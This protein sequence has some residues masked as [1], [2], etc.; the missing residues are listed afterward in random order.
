MTS[1][2]MFHPDA[3]HAVHEV[4]YATLRVR[5]PGHAQR[6]THLEVRQAFGRLAFANRLRQGANMASAMDVARGF[7]E[8]P[9]RDESLRLSQ[10]DLP[11]DVLVAL[12]DR[13]F[14]RDVLDGWLRLP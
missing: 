7:T 11:L 6:A 9:I 3:T 13:Q 14:A 8:P 12:S 4:Q 5:H 10:P 2:G 1:Q